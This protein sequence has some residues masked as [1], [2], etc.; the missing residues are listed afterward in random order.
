MD[1][2]YPVNPGLLTRGS[3][4]SGANPRL[5]AWGHLRYAKEVV[6]LVD[7][8]SGEDPDNQPGH[9]RKN[10]AATVLIGLSVASEVI[11][12]MTDILG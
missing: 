7:S 8:P 11:D 12:I 5:T 9:D 1:P 10:L 4:C 6:V 3:C 2:C